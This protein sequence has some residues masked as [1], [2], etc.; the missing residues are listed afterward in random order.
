[1]MERCVVLTQRAKPAAKLAVCIGRGP[2]YYFFEIFVSFLFSQSLP[3]LSL[4]CCGCL[5]FAYYGYAI[6]LGDPQLR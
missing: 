1:M 5:I 4:S 6:D 3:W 2:S